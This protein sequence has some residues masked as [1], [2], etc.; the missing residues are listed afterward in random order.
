MYQKKAKTRICS[1]ERVILNPKVEKKTTGN[2]KAKKKKAVQPQELA[3]QLIIMIGDRGTG[4]GSRM[5]GHLK[6]GGS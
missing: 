1:R 6:Y 5:R 3:K 2:P 4:V